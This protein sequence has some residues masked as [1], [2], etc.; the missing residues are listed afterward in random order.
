MEK[1]QV[2]KREINFITAERSLAQGHMACQTV[3]HKAPMVVHTWNEQNMSRFSHI[4]YLYKKFHKSLVRVVCFDGHLREAWVRWGHCN[5][6]L[7][8]CRYREESLWLGQHK[9]AH[10]FT[11]SIESQPLPSYSVDSGQWRRG[12]RKRPT[13][14]GSTSIK[15][16]VNKKLR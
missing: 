3:Y 5:R 2:M 6:H 7:V 4:N 16:F 14:L 13:H 1:P 12:G 11:F 9:E 15:V 8:H 10:F